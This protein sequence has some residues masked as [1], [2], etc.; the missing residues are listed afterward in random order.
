MEDRAE[1]NSAAGSAGFS[2][3]APAAGEGL[4]EGALAEALGVRRHTLR[5]L[6]TMKLEE[7]VHWRKERQAVVYTEEGL[8]RLREL[9]VP[10]EAPGD[11]GGPAEVNGLKMEDGAP[12]G[13]TF[14]DPPPERVWRPFTKG[15][16]TVVKIR[17]ILN[18]PHVLEGQ[19]EDREA[20]IVRLRVRPSK[21]WRPGMR[22]PCVQLSTDYFEYCGRLPR[23]WG[24]WV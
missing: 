18:N 5:E 23:S 10:G 3:A 2:P 13:A 11:G 22:L 12:S 9:M 20:T 4:L 14:W 15:P 16:T 7:G 21:L 1:K 19:L 6:R 8:A 24:R 17:R